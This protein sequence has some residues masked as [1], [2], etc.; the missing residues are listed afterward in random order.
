MGSVVVV[1]LYVGAS[2]VFQCLC[3]AF[4]GGLVLGWTH[5][6]HTFPQGVLA[7]ITEPV[8]DVGLPLCSVAVVAL[9]GTGSAP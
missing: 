8:L 9:S 1:L 3:S 4:L 2:L 6:S 5:S 7:I